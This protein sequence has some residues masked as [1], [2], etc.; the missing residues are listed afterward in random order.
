MTIKDI[1]EEDIKAEY[2]QGNF[3]P[4]DYKSREV[5]RPKWLEDNLTLEHQ[6]ELHRQAEELESKISEFRAKLGL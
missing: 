5:V 1:L 3:L 2:R 6:E 4:A